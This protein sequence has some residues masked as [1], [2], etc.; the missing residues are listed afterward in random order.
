MKNQDSKIV[1]KDMA[2][3]IIETARDDN[4]C[5]V[6][7]AEFLAIDIELNLDNGDT[8]YNFE[9]MSFLSIGEVGCSIH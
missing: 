7:Y 3:M 8:V 1:E 5:L 9:D 6:D 2:T 4:K